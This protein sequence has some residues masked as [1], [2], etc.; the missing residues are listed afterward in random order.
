[1]VRFSLRTIGL[2]G[3]ALGLLV[4]CNPSQPKAEPPKPTPAPTT[5]AP[6]SGA[7]SNPPGTPA[8]P[9]AVAPT[10][11]LE[12]AQRRAEQKPDD[13]QA[14]IELAKAALKE[15][16]AVSVR[17]LRKALQLDPDDAEARQALVGILTQFGYFDRILELWEERLKRKPDDVAALLGVA[18]IY[19]N[20]VANPEAQNLLDRAAQLA[21][22][23]MEAATERAYG[24]Y[25]MR[26]FDKAIEAMQG[27]VAKNP[28]NDALL[29]QLSEMQRGG[30][31][32]AEAEAT[33]KKAM[34]LRPNQQRY[35]R[36]MAH[37]LATCDRKE[38][39]P[40]AEREA[41]K[42]LAL[43]ADD[44]EAQYWLAMSLDG[45]GKTAEA[46]KAYEE[47]TKRD[48]A[49][50]RAAYRLGRLYQQNGKTAEG[51]ALLQQFSEMDKNLSQ[52]GEGVKA[53]QKSPDK[54]ESYIRMAG[55]M[56]KKGE[57][58]YG[59]ALLRRALQRFPN[60]AKLRESLRDLLTESGRQ[61]EAAQL[62]TRTQETGTR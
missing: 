53:L 51:Q 48:L 33:L 43:Q 21:P 11:S 38:R 18:R 47:V 54:P 19:Q 59:I 5:T 4:G 50:E 14:Q 31:R 40:E 27:A 25:K 42:A 44:V 39:L 46:I 3:A 7:T 61:S 45:Q 52:V 23:S 13:K 58:G 15:K 36:Q 1:M 55:L 22:D 2:V 16:P 49:F 57:A 62:E 6:G 24:Y 8:N 12:E 28:N 56:Q 35:H 26:L 32:Y 29:Y 60:D 37:I 41:R 30:A 34:A 20:I 9:V 17:A 10:L